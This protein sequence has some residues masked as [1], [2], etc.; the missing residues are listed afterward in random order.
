MAQLIAEGNIRIRGK[1]ENILR[2]LQEEL[3]PIY[4]LKDD[5]VEERS[6]HLEQTDHGW[7]VILSRDP[8]TSSNIYFKGSDTHWIETDSETIEISF[9]NGGKTKEDQVIC[10]DRYEGPWSPRVDFWKEKAVKHRVDIR[11]FSWSGK[12]WSSVMTFYRNGDIE[13][14]ARKYEDFLWDCPYPDFESLY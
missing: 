8:D 5:L 14:T 3:T 9:S 12:A 4:E 13:E 11:I 2:F 7:S 6:I 1:R 10:L